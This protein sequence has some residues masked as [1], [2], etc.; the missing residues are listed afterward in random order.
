MIA[1]ARAAAFQILLAVTSVDMHSDELLRSPQVDALAVQDRA[2]ATTLVLG[3]LRWQIKLDAQIRA[4]LARPDTKLTPPVET[5]LR[6]GAY[7][8]FYL[9]RIPAYAAI[10]ESVELAKQAGETFAAGMV[11][12]ILRKIA[13]LPKPSPAAAPGNPARLAEAYA[14]PAWMVARWA[15]AYGL[16]AA[17]AICQFDQEP[18]AVCVRLLDPEVEQ[19]LADEGVELAPG[20]FLAAARRVVSGDIV[21]SEAFRSGRVRIQEEGSQLVAELAG[22]G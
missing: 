21:R 22:S 19:S 16:D 11:N 5:A 18:A 2:L 10:G 12:A 8:L 1:P 9:D 15:R 6:L 3:T 14:H 4:L 13:R 20:E 7:Q 17:A